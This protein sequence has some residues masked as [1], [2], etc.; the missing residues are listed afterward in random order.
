[1]GNL[2][3][4]TLGHLPKTYPSK[5]TWHQIYLNFADGSGNDFAQQ[6]LTRN[7]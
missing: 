4:M 1:M 3:L 7:L 6:Y 5:T 2:Q